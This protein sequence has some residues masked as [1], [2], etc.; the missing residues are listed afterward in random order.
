MKMVNVVSIGVSAIAVLALTWASSKFIFKS[1]F[2]PR[3][4]L[5]NVIVVA[6][7]LGIAGMLTKKTVGGMGLESIPAKIANK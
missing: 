3:Q 2:D 7:T 6:I 5:V 4:A 1:E